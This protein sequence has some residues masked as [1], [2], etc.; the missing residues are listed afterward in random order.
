MAEASKCVFTPGRK[1]VMDLLDEG[2]WIRVGMGHLTSVARLL[3]CAAVSSLTV[4]VPALGVLFYTDL[5]L[6]FLLVLLLNRRLRS[7]VA[8]SRTFLFGVRKLRRDRLFL[9]CLLYISGA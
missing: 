8:V 5:S 2:E 3:G 9:F 7:P 6:L 1:E 4:S